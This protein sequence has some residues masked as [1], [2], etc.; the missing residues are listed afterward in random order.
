MALNKL[1]LIVFDMDGTL[2]D[3]MGCLEDWIYRAIKDH[4]AS[5]VTPAAV[6]AAFGP[7]ERKIIE[8]FVPVDRAAACLEAYYTLCEAEHS[9]VKVYPGVAEMLRQ[10]GRL[11]T[12]MALCTGKSRRATEI[13]LER[14]GWQ[15]HFKFVVTGDDM[16][17]FKPDPDGLNQILARG[18]FERS[19]AIFV[20]D[21]HADIAAAANAGILSGHALWSRP[22]PLPTGAPKP[23]YELAAPLDL[24]ALL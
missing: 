10:I 15:E 2:T 21:S 12:P 9:R 22:G 13:S 8:A 1:D 24:L 4:C 7:T 23:S 19:R 18:S 5:S 11:G 6:T 20:G 17:R 14:L 3:T 16:A